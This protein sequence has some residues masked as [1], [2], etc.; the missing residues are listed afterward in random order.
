MSVVRAFALVEEYF[1]I[2]RPGS[3]R[4]GPGMRGCNMVLHVATFSPREIG[5]VAK[6]GPGQDFP[7]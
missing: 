5:I 2:S 4:S 1:P 6:S 7:V 3:N